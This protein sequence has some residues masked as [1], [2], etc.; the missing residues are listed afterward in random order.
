MRFWRILT[1][2]YTKQI[3]SGLTYYYTRYSH[4]IL[5]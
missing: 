3:D 2:N 4:S 1:V 5:M